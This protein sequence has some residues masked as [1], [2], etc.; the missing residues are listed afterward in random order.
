[1]MLH[2]QSNGKAEHC[3]G[4]LQLRKSRRRKKGT[5]CHVG[6][7]LVSGVIFMN[8]SAKSIMGV[9]LRGLAWL[10][11]VIA[12]LAFWVGGRA[13]S[14]F[15][16]VERMLAEVEGLGI[17]AVCAG[18]GVLLKLASKRLEATDD[19]RTTSPEAETIQK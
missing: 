7:A 15:A 14:E 8:A 6:C 2:L 19:N 4:S 3:S 11:F 5:N 10:L 17:T 9:V 1:M 13:I 12:G 16:G 18:I